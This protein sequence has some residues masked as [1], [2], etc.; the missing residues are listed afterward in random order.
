M[1]E[2]K[3][4]GTIHNIHNTMYE[5]PGG[6]IDIY[7][8]KFVPLLGLQ[9]KLQGMCTVAVDVRDQPIK[10]SHPVLSNIVVGCIVLGSQTNVDFSTTDHINATTFVGMD[11]CFCTVKIHDS[12]ITCMQTI[13][14][15]VVHLAIVKSCICIFTTTNNP[16]FT[17]FQKFT[18][19]R[20]TSCTFTHNHPIVS[21]L[22]ET[23]LRYIN[24]G[25][26]PST[27]QT[28]PCLVC[29]GKL[30]NFNILRV[31]HI[32]PTKNCRFAFAFADNC[33]VVAIDMREMSVMMSACSNHFMLSL[34]NFD[35]HRIRPRAVV[36]F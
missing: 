3:E 22:F 34:S 1:F 14:S 21:T 28:I 6:K 29:D 12:N 10:M 8:K 36:S 7:H 13:I 17:I 26:S 32:K 9:Y 19:C 31:V 11:V 23:T 18:S 35:F 33:D 5:Y 20:C 30:S 2:A 24:I 16:I 4:W 25:P 27:I 15:I